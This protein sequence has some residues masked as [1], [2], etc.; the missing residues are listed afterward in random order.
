M[1]MHVGS[2]LCGAIAFE[3]SGDPLTMTYCHC[4]RCRKAGGHVTVMVKAKDFRWIRGKELVVRYEP[5][6]PWT[7]VRYFCR[8]CGTYLGEPEAQ[9]DAFPICAQ[10][11]DDDPGIRPM[12]H[13]HVSDKGVWYEITDGL[14]QYDDAPPLS[15]FRPQK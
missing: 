10:L 9:P 11:F 15:A 7:L 1:S 6:A 14:P 12:L 2:C 3:L 13:E 8:D 5:P 4:S